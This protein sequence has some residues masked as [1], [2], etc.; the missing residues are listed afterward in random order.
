MLSLILTVTFLVLLFLR[1]PVSM[2]I[3][4]AT[5]IPLM[6]LGKNLAIVPQYMLEGVHSVPLL[7]VPFFILAG[8]IFNTMGLSKRIW[9]FA[10]HLVGHHK[11]GMGHVM[12]VANMIFAGISGSALADAAGLG[13]IGIPA[14]EKQGYRRSFSTAIA[15]CSSV[16]GPMI[17]PSI[18]LILYGVLAQVSIGRLFIAGVV[19]GLII[20]LAM[21]ATIYFFAATGREPCPVQP[22]KSL[23]QV[24][25]SFVRNSPALV[26]PVIIIMG[27]G[28]GVITPTEVGVVA[29]LYAIV[30]GCFYREASLK[31]IYAS[32][33]DSVKSTTMIMVIIAVSTVAGWVYA[34]EGT[35]LKLAEWMFTLT[36]NKFLLLL[37]INLFLLV[38]GCLLEPIPV[39]ILTTPIFLPIVQQLGLDPVQFGIVMSFNITIGIITPPMGIGLYVMMGVI[40]IKFETLVRVCLPFF[41]PLIACLLLF[42]YVPEISMWLPNLLMGAP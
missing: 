27:M 11:G 3:G 16:I 6:I 42:T 24:G 37:L 33:V 5:L 1:V 32:L 18:N 15:L 25:R 34:Y 21:M 39:L 9:D 40:D 36:Q 4:I 22:R 28:F 12:V 10:L 8:N 41:I 20:G 23:P 29:T 13:L 19:P 35:S 31:Q 2:A 17:P 30:L 38:L 7:A 26:I 14:M